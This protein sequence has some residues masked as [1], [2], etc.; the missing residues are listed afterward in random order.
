MYEQ[1]VNIVTSLM[2][3]QGGIVEVQEEGGVE[4]MR[5]GGEM[6]I[7]LKVGEAG[8]GKEGRVVMI[9]EILGGE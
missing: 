3:M 2:I 6:I 7:S 4:V 5:G 1:V 8:V 9:T